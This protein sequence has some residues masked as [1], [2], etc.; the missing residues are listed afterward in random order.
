MKAGGAV[1][2]KEGHAREAVV[3]FL[4]MA[5]DTLEQNIAQ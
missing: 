3:T 1:G 4:T 2:E 5:R